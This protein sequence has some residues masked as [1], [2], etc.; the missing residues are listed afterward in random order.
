M[1]LLGLVGMR[2]A[3]GDRGDRGA[4]EAVEG[5][6]RQIRSSAGLGRGGEVKILVC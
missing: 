1:G 2:G 5:G 6:G 3:R 4:V